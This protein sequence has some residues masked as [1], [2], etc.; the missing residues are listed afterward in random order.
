M[1]KN[2]VVTV[3]LRLLCVLLVFFMFWVTMGSQPIRS[4]TVD[5]GQVLIHSVLAVIAGP[6]LPLFWGGSFLGV[7][8]VLFFWCALLITAFGS[9]DA[10]TRRWFYV[11]FG[12]YIV[13]TSI[14][15]IGTIGMGLIA[16]SHAIG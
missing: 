7:P 6:V 14:G 10:R 16:M 15:I 4:R 12:V 8:I 5:I 13:L 3:W 1:T 11:L 2:P 9:K